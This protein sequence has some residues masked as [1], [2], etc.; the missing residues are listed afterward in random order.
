MKGGRAQFSLR[1]T[2]SADFSCGV[3]DLVVEV[4]LE[5]VAVA[6]GPTNSGSTTTRLV[7]FARAAARGG[8][9][10]DFTLRVCDLKSGAL[11][12]A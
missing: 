5:V 6:I 10:Q 12:S 1:P 4:L 2:G 3:R 11:T 9:S 7:Q 8:L